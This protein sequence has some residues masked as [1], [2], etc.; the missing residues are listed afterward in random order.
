M[1]CKRRS[2]LIELPKKLIQLC[3]YMASSKHEKFLYPVQTVQATKTHLFIRPKSTT[4]IQSPQFG[5]ALTLGSILKLKTERLDRITKC[6]LVLKEKSATLI[7]VKSLRY[8]LSNTLITSTDSDSSAS[9]TT[10]FF[11]KK[12][13]KSSKIQTQIFRKASDYL[14][15]DQIC[16]MLPLIATS[17][18]ILF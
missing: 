9:K 5:G 8:K 11:K 3:L 4:I 12:Y 13:T 14:G 18:A 15:S 2:K 10:L 16:I 6:Q 1:R 7:T 17:T